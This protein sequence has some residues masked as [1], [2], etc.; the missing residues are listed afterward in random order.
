MFNVVRNLAGFPANSVPYPVDTAA[1]I[2]KGNLVK[3][4]SNK[5]TNATSSTSSDAIL[6][7]AAETVAA[8]TK[9]TILVYDNPIS[10]I[11]GNYDSLPTIFTQVKTNASASGFVSTTGGPL[12]IINVDTKAQTADAVIKS[13][14]FK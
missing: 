2:N 11:R 9:D 10:V 14:I 13:H 7:I 3:V 6:G 1:T 4:A 5:V 12:L 8:G